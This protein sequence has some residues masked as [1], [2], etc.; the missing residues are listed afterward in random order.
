MACYLCRLTLTLM[1]SSTYLRSAKHWSY[2]ATAS[3]PTRCATTSVTMI[4]ASQRTSLTLMALSRYV[5]T[6][7]PHSVCSQSTKI[8]MGKLQTTMIQLP[9]ACNEVIGGSGL[10]SPGSTDPSLDNPAS[11]WQK[12][13]WTSLEGTWVL[14]LVLISVQRPKAE[15][16]IK[17]KLISVSYA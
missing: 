8:A 12:Y 9:R 6:T 15:G 2:L 14:Y 5:P 4:T 11:D 7:L 10:E 13:N 3:H 17:A 16:G 1:G